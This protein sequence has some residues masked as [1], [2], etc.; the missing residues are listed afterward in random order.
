MAG[1]EHIERY[2]MA[3]GGEFVAGHAER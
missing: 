2:G 1:A 3:I